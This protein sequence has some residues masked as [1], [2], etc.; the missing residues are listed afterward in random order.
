VADKKH[1]INLGFS[2]DISNLQMMKEQQ[3][4]KA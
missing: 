4:T 2:K 1:K 3:E